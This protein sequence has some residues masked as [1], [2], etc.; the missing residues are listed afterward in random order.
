M[1]EAALHF[2]QQYPNLALVSCF[3]LAIFVA[4]I[5]IIP[6][7]FV[8]AAA[9]LFFGF[10]EGI[11]I[12]FAGETLGAALAFSLYRRGFKKSV[13]HQLEKYKSAQALLNAGNKDAFWLIFS[14]RLIP[15]LPSGVVTFTAAMGRASLLIF[16]AAGALG[17]FPSLLLEGYAALQVKEFG[18]QGKLILVLLALAL[19]YFVIKHILYPNRRQR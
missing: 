4:V 1:K 11:A 2:F 10:W 7:F 14:L 16:I 19:I 15:V 9:V 13:R 3:S 12:T 18:W 5:G 6:S 8:S 17:K